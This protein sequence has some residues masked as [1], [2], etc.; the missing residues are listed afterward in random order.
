MKVTWNES[1]Q[2]ALECL[3]RCATHRFRG[4]CF[5]PRP[6]HQVYF[7][8]VCGSH[9]YEVENM[10]SWVQRLATYSRWQIPTFRIN[11]TS[12]S[13]GLHRTSAGFFSSV[14]ARSNYSPRA[15]TASSQSFIAGN[16][17]KSATSHWT[18]YNV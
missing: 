12:P 2:R 4:C 16:Y 11:I 13:S 8:E 6:Y 15:T 9:G 18:F 10:L 3:Q 1:V 7:H 5:K 17:N 14:P